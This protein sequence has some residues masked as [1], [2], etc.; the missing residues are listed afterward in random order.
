[1]ALWGT[2]RH[3]M[4][5]SVPTDSSEF[6]Q[7]FFDKTPEDPHWQL[8][9]IQKETEQ[10]IATQLADRRGIALITSG[11]TI[12]PLDPENDT[13]VDAAPQGQEQ[14][15]PACAEYLLQ[16]GY[17]VIFVHREGSLRPFTRHFQK[18][19]QNGAFMD[20]FRLENM[21]LVL[22]GVDI[23]Q[24]L[25]FQKIAQLYT[26][27]STRVLHLSFTSV[28][29]YLMLT[30]L[31]AKAMEVVKDR[32]IVVLA[33]TLLHFYVPMDPS[34][35]ATEASEDT[36]G[37]STS[38]SVSSSSS[39]H[40]KMK[41]IKKFAKNVAKKKNEEFSVN[42][43]RVPNIIRSIR[44]DWC[45]KA[46]LVTCKHQLAS[47]EAIEAAHGDLEKWGVDV[48]AGYH[49]S[50]EILLITEQEEAIVTCPRRRG[51]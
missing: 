10:F 32:G 22:S 33:A 50:R 21:G 24:Q 18:Y 34:A 9:A 12:V 5:G 16:L 35:T 14:Q 28:Q 11:A 8:S 3:R 41:H 1:M 23:P 39:K 43:V 44:K 17:A 29:Q 38:S 4:G 31:A 49:H 2:L 45:P 13:F 26:E 15:G 37:A 6:V 25:Q 46:F 19:I 27:C 48:I 42:F 36:D 30:R 40:S 47:G 20:M 7:D 51:H